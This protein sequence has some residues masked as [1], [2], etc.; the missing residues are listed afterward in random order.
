MTEGAATPQLADSAQ[1]VVRISRAM[2]QVRMSVG[3]VVFGVL[4]TASVIVA[5][6]SDAKK[7]P[8]APSP[9]AASEAS[10]DAG[11]VTAAVA[12]TTADAGGAA[13]PDKAAECEALLD[14][15]NSSMD[16]ERIA[17]DKAC[18]K[19]ADCMPVKSRACAFNCVNAAIPKA[20][21]KDWTENLKKVT[22][23]QCKKWNEMDCAK[24]RTK[25]APTCQDR[26]VACDKGKC[27]LKDK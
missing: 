22:D 18:K 19:D 8:V 6:G 25:P 15:A 26:K 11:A 5:C 13:K 4:A 27:I 2:N 20:E 16:A 21:E 14:D 24:L 17:V 23:N 7:E 9:P 3:G 12:P 1:R 10:A